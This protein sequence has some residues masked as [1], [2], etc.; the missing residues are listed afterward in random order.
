MR[1][2]A[3]IAKIMDELVELGEKVRSTRRE[4]STGSDIVDVE[5][6]HEWITRC[7]SFAGRVFGRDS[8]YYKAMIDESL[9]HEYYS[10]FEKFVAQLNALA[11]DVRAGALFEVERLVEASVF[12]DLLEQAEHLS[13]NGYKPPAAVITGCVLEETLRRL[14]DRHGVALGPSPKLDWMNAELAKVGAYQKLTQK[15]VTA[16]ADIRNSA[17]HGKWKEF[18]DADVE[19]MIRD[20]RD[21][22]TRHYS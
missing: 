19:N 16:L 12:D 5:Q 11:A 3:H 14:C 8:E 1:D 2:A 17:A 4:D 20:V 6:Y 9:S 10:D 13:A 18:T 7:R 22:V 21:F 15:K